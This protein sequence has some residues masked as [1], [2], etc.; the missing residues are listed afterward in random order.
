MP[1]RGS[2]FLGLSDR[3][4][5]L[6]HTSIAGDIIVAAPWRRTVAQPASGTALRHALRQSKDLW[7]KG[8][9]QEGAGRTKRSGAD[10]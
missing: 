4:R 1:T 9:G 5:D 8:T 10:A 7:G 2:T 3:R 6:V